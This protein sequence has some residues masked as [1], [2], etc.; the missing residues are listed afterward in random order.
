MKVEIPQILWNCEDA[1][2]GLPT[3]LM[4]ISLLPVPVMVPLPAPVVSTSYKHANSNSYARTYCLATAGNCTD[5]N[6]WNVEL[7]L[8]S[9]SESGIE[10]DD[11]DSVNG[12]D[13]T[14]PTTTISTTSSTS[15]TTAAAV[16]A[17]DDSITASA[18]KSTIPPRNYKTK[19][20]FI[21]ALT[22]H[23]G[24]VN[25]VS[26][27]PNGIHLATA[28][29]TGSIIIWSV[30]T[31]ATD[32]ATTSVPNRYWT[33][34]CIQKES[35]LAVKIISSSSRNLDSIVDLSWS[36]DSKRFVVGTIDHTVMIFE[37][38]HYNN[39]SIVTSN[40]S[41]TN[42][43]SDNSTTTV[44]PT[45]R[46]QSEWKMIYRNSSYHTHYVQGVSFDPLQVYIA[47]Q[48]SDRTVRL[49]QRKD[50]GESKRKNSNSTSINHQALSTTTNTIHSLSQGKTPSVVE[51]TTATNSSSISTSSTQSSPLQ[52]QR[53]FTSL[54][55]DEYPNAELE[56][57]SRST[58]ATATVTKKQHE[59]FLLTK[60]KFELLIKTKQIKYRSQSDEFDA[61]RN[62]SLQ[63]NVKQY[64]FASET[65]LESFVRRLSWT[66]DGAY[67]ILPAAA[68]SFSNDT[69]SS[70]PCDSKFATLI[71][72]RHRYDE[73]WK[74]LGGLDKPSIAIRPNPVLFQLPTTSDGEVVSTT[75]TK[76]NFDESKENYCNNNPNSTNPTDTST[77]NNNSNN[78]NNTTSGMAY[79]NIFAVLTWDTVLIYDTIHD[80]PLAVAR[81]LHYAN[82]VDGAW[83][84]D[85]HTLLV[86]STD[87]YISILRFN[88]GE[89]GEV[90]NPPRSFVPLSVD[91]APLFSSSSTSTQNVGN[92]VAL[93]PPCD[94][95]SKV[96]HVPPK[97]KTRITPSLVV[98][99]NH[100]NLNSKDESQLE[101]VSH[102]R[103]ASEAAMAGA[104]N[105][106]S[107]VEVTESSVTAGT[108]SVTGEV[109]DD[110]ENTILHSNI[111]ASSQQQYVTP[112]PM[113]KKQK[114]RIQPI[115]LIP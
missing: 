31:S 92:Q 5:I 88:N 64:L 115:Q 41:T 61:S 1:S 83:T 19:I 89:L 27:S 105:K 93:I 42:S 8:Q 109:N 108:T 32:T 20:D 90:Y 85:G 22:R 106:L 16:T 71:Y 63:T 13:G 50:C 28:S 101:R 30:P 49:W 60:N 2:K 84:S 76:M 24:P 103:S 99:N 98:V 87:G 35:D 57:N 70:T 37:D 12:V 80:Q 68:W 82:I 11:I 38:I 81:G 95:G 114:K 91:Q 3:A 69:K 96:V 75:S 110:E 6:L 36:T 58:I 17:V 74:V 34:R 73:P 44:P 111:N 40:T 97:K 51:T 7:P 94:P 21:C 72:Q 4:S 102:K 56:P 113:M 10:K 59:Q 54:T 43:N 9:E 66:V 48:S 107:L 79:R 14:E 65:S 46:L 53:S 55:N 62:P 18:P 78:M 26:F 100:Q 15:T 25:T 39:N 47:T 52:Q 45:T 67:L 112:P 104:V 23:E 33:K 86:C 77:S 29:D